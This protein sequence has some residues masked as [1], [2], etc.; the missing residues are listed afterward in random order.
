MSDSDAQV[1]K[2]RRGTGVPLRKGQQ[3]KIINT[4][5]DQVVDTWA[6]DATDST[7][8]LSM[9]HVR[10]S[11][12]KISVAAGDS[13]VDNHRKPMLT[14]VED[15]TPGVHD[16]LIAACDKYRYK[17]LGV[18]GYH[19]SCT[20]NFHAAIKEVGLELDFI[21]SPLNL[22]MN[23]PV[24]ADTTLKF[25]GPVSSAGQYVTLK[26]EVDLTLVMSACPQDIVGINGDGP[27]DVHFVVT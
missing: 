21:P 13:L 7:I 25:E 4:Y 2:A 15:T 12:H 14:I 1:L 5:G 16:T 8:H 9:P 22:F 11:L 23:I 18:V 6:L 17:G 20:D 10:A 27:A 3:I 26:A 19:D 24:A